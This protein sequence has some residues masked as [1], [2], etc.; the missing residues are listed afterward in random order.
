[1]KKILIKIIN[2]LP[3]IRGLYKQVCAFNENACFPPGHFYSTIVNV[4]EI[5][6]NENKIWK[7]IL[8]DGI[9]DINLNT[10]EQLK[11]LEEIAVFYSEM[12]FKE[13]CN[14]TLRYKF[15]NGMYSYT[16]GIVLYGLLR[17]IK[18][19]QIIEVGSGHSSAL[20]LDINNLFFKNAINLTFI[21]PFP[22]RL[23]TLLTKRDKE[24]LTI[25]EKK[26]QEIDFDIFEKLEKDDILFIDSTHVSKCGSDVNYILFEILPRLKQGVY[27]HF[28]D[29]F[30]PFEYPKE[31]VYKGYNWNENYLLRAF[32][33]NNDKYK[34]KLFSDY[35]H[36]Y[37][38]DAF[39][40]MPLTYKNSGGNL[41]LQ[42]V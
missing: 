38:K 40:T 18:P 2:Q 21:E 34:I 1:M 23:N 22:L 3:Y 8:T 37:H 20:M 13:S 41:W 7:G 15:E 4:N 30:Y 14:E 26:I 32:L 5:K 19:K 33:T 25:I 6:Q 12:P 35:V 9:K 36:L 31:W 29:I 24:T 17:K 42:K 39:K 27:I 28:H 11:L 10:E 16:D